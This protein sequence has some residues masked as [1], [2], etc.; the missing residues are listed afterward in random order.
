MERRVLIAIFL[1]FIVIYAWQ[2]FF[3]R[4]APKPAASGA[5][6]AGP[7]TPATQ[8]AAPTAA[9]PAYAPAESPTQPVAAP[10]SATVVG[11]REERDVTV[12]TGDIVAVFTNR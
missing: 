9:T 7:P 3:V 1:S 4:P 10:V 2:A 8:T 12:E 5:T 6:A 11:E